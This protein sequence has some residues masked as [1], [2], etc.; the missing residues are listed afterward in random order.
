MPDTDR[1]LAALQSLLADNVAGDISP[2]DV[3][4]MLV[5][6]S[7]K[8]GEMYIS[9]P[10]ATTISDTTNYFDVAGTYTA[11]ALK[12]F[13]MNTN[14]QLRYIGTPT[15]EVLVFANLS[16]T[17]AGNNDIVHLEFRKNGADVSGSDAMRKVNTGADVGAMSI[18]GITGMATNDFLTIAVRNETATDNVTG[19]EAHVLAVGV[20][21]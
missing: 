11:G 2:Q 10:A 3:R 14:G 21:I 16:L 19:V 12:Q 5:S 15:I 7:I 1:T 20:V 4:D 13:D 17:V 18:V 8:Y 9:T 6:L